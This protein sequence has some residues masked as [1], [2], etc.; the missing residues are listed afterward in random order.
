M[1]NL[2]NLWT[3]G[4]AGAI[5]IT[6]GS[7]PVF[8]DCGFLRNNAWLEASHLAVPSGPAAAQA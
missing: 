3:D 6:E 7:V 1:E 4:M 8:S 5:I 2:A